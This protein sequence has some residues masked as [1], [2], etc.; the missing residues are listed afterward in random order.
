MTGSDSIVFKGLTIPYIITYSQKRKSISIIVH[1]TKQIEIKAPA[2]TPASYIHDLAGKKASWIA[3][4]LIALDSMTGL[5]V[6][7]NYQEGEVFFFLGTPFTLAVLAGNNDGGVRCDAGH[8][9]VNNPWPLPGSDQT[10]CT[11][12]MVQDWYRDQASRIIQ[13]KV[14]EFSQIL[15]VDPPLFKLKN[16]RRRWGSCN[17]KNN[18]NF[19]I[20]LTMAPISLVEYVVLHELCHIRHKNHSREF[21]DS[22]RVV[23]PDY[24]K[25]RGLL[26]REGL[27]YVL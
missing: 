8:L 21:W 14:Q 22:L 5:P 6:E 12:K 13:E 18:L 15:G 10:N 11:R 4:K 9:V 3:N 23:M 2:G 7:R 19:N 20:R 1:R 17:H 24:S 25:R 26:K 16:V 27:R